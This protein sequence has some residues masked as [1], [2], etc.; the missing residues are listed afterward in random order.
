MCIEGL[1]LCKKFVICECCLSVSSIMPG[2]FYSIPYL[3]AVI[4]I[5]Q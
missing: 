3:D 5:G 1:E 4:I 2:L